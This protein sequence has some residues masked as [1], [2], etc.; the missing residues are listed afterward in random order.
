[1]EEGFHIIEKSSVKERDLPIFKKMSIVNWIKNIR[2]EGFNQFESYTV[3]GLEDLLEKISNPQD[4]SEK[5]R[6]IL[7]DQSNYLVST[8]NIFQFLIDNSIGVWEKNPTVK[9]ASGEVID[10]SAIFGELER[11]DVNWFYQQLNIQS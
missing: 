11:K 4:F 5:L 3:V 9:T 2:N 10:L 7:I 1:M 8:G 6:K